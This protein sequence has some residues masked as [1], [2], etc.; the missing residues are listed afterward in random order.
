MTYAAVSS[1][2]V[3]QRVGSIPA[4]YNQA[5]WRGPGRAREQESQI[6]AFLGLGLPLVLS[7]L[8][9]RPC[10]KQGRP[11]KAAFLLLNISSLA[12]KYLRNSFFF[13]CF[14]SLN[15]LSIS[16]TCGQSQPQGTDKGILTV[17]VRMKQ[18]TKYGKV[19]NSD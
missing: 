3:A 6:V 1:L 9:L 4:C 2:P 5:I 10:G 11:C 7:L 12:A 14:E 17:G 13:R 15:I 8:H 19:S 18:Y 16:S